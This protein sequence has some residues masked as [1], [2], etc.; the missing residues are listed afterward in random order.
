MSDETKYSDACYLPASGFTRTHEAVHEWVGEVVRYARTEFAGEAIKAC[1]W[2]YREQ[3]CQYLSCDLGSVS[4]DKSFPITLAAE[5]E[6]YFADV[7]GGAAEADLYDLP[8]ALHVAGLICRA[9]DAQVSVA[10]VANE[11]NEKIL[12]RPLGPGETNGAINTAFS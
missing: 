7:C 8:E 5:G 9:L 1:I 3:G 12:A 11:V 10:L 6:H 2:A 4:S